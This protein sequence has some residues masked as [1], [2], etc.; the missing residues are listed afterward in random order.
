MMSM[1]QLKFAIG[2]L[3]ITGLSIFLMLQQQNVS[4]LHAENKSSAQ[5][6]TL[7]SLP[8]PQ[9]RNA[10]ISINPLAKAG[11]GFSSIVASNEPLDLPGADV[12]LSDS[13]AGV[14]KSGANDQ[15]AQIPQHGGRAIWESHVMNQV[16][17][18]CINYAMY[19]QWQFP[20]SLDQAAPYLATDLSMDVVKSN[21]VI[22]FQGSITDI[23]Y[24]GRT[25]VVMGKESWQG[26][27]GQ[28]MKAYGFANGKG[29]VCFREQNDFSV[30]ESRHTIPPLNQ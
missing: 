29:G 16:S 23:T 19:H 8:Q 21:C 27:D 18:A 14:G 6:A 4:K 15:P 3:M 2:A 12:V 30:F 25:V 17:Q 24:P 22:V 7:N 1:N 26:L 11:A 5:P 9:A 13:G 20:T 10:A 28:W